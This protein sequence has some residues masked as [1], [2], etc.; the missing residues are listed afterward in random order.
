MNFVCTCV[1]DGYPKEDCMLRN[2]L[3][4]R[5]CRLSGGCDFKCD[6]EDFVIP[7]CILTTDNSPEAR[8]TFIYECEHLAVGFLHTVREERNSTHE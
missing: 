7:G 5:A 2:N 1:D 8:E 6:E 4:C 3:C